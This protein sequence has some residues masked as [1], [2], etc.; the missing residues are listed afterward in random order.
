M[1]SIQTAPRKEEGRDNA[2]IKHNNSTMFGQITGHTE[3]FST[4]LGQEMKLQLGRGAQPMAELEQDHVTSEL[5]AKP[6]TTQKPDP[7][8]NHVENS[9]FGCLP[10]RSSLGSQQ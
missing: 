3:V 8:E 10:G 2:K 1:S 5:P 4:H 9:H 6:I 7:T